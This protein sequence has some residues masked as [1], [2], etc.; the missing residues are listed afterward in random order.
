M[1]TKSTYVTYNELFDRMPTEEELND[2]VKGLNAFNT[3]VLTSRLNTMLWHSMRSQNPQD[4]GSLSKFQHWFAG[5]IFDDDAQ[6]R[7]RQRL[8]A[9]DPKLRPVCIPLQ[10]LNIIRLAL[11]V[12]EGDENSRPDSS[13]MHTHRFGT[14][15]LI[16][17]DLFVTAEEKENLKTGSLDDRRKQLML[18]LLGTFELSNPTRLRNLLFRSYA[19]YRIVLRDPLLVS[20]IKKECGGLDIERE[21]EKQFS[22]S[23]MDWLSLVFGV[24]TLLLVHTQA[25]F[26]N[27]PGLFLLNRKT[28]LPASNLSQTQIDAFFDMLSWGFDELRAEVRKE[29]RVDDRLDIVPFKSKP[30]FVTAPDY[31]ACVDFGLLSEKMHNGPY[32]LLAN[33]LAEGDR[34]KMFNAWGILFETYVNWL[35]D[36]LNGLHSAVFF[37]DTRWEDG[38]RAFDALFIKKRMVVTMEFKGGF[39]PQSARYSNDLDKFMT[40][41]MS[42]IGD[43]C[44]QLARDIGALFPVNQPAKKLRNVTIPSNTLYVLPVL[45]VQDLMLRSPFINYFLNQRFQSERAAYAVRS[46]VEVLPLTVIQITNLENM[47]EMAE[48]L[49]FDMMHFLH[50]RCQID[51][52]MLGELEDFLRKTPEAREDR[53]SKRFQ[54]IF[55]RSHDEMSTVLFKRPDGP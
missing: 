15:S 29:R 11:S 47:V 23:L 49:N 13:R 37:P 25:D 46:D 18:Q 24:Q 33:R 19:T 41:L 27:Q 50:S 48:A 5:N 4:V 3:V 6:H 53:C 17:N 52:E 34:S 32:F 43:G 35:L 30:L 20:R 39:L 44:H 12:A 51:S 36:S 9:Q 16:V 21:F 8:G 54:E 10:L 38:R 14:A 2:L 42:R 22:I 26:I 55:D 7:L 40:T 45:V 31:Y 1:P 28:L